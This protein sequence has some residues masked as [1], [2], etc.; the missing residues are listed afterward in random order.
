MSD[1]PSY[2]E[3]APYSIANTRIPRSRGTRTGF[4]GLARAAQLPLFA[5]TVLLSSA[6]MFLVEPMFARM[7]LPLLGGTPA[8]WNTCMVFFQICLLAGYAYA[9]VSA[10]WLNVRQQAWIQLGLLLLAILVLP[11]AV[12]RG[13]H[14]PAEGN[15]TGWL[16]ALLAV[17]VGLPFFVVSTTGP[18]IQRWM[19]CTSHR[20][21]ADPYFLYAAS[22]LGSV[23]A[24]LTYPSL[25][26]PLVRLATQSHIWTLGYGLLIV[27]T[28]LCA[29]YTPKALTTKD[30]VD[31]GAPIGMAR[32]AR[33]ILLAFVPSSLLL[34]V[35][36]FMTTDIAAV[37]LF[38]IVPLAIYLLSF[39]LVFSQRPLLPD[40]V[41]NRAL[42]IAILGVIFLMLGKVGQPIWLVLGLHLA[43]FFFTS[44][45]CHGALAKDRPSAD[46]L[47]DFYFTMSIGGVLGGLFNALLAPAIFRSAA[48]YPIM[49]VLACLILPARKSWKSDGHPKWIWMA[50]MVVATMAWSIERFLPA[51]VGVNHISIRMIW[52]GMP[53]LLS[54]ATIGHRWLFAATIAV[55]LAITGTSGLQHATLLEARRSFFGIHRV[56]L[57]ADGPFNDLYHGSTVHGRQRRGADGLPTDAETALTYYHRTGPIGQL[58]TGSGRLPS[59]P[60]IAV[61]GL[62]VGSLAAYAKEGTRLTYYEIDPT[63]RWVADESGYFTFLQAA[64]SRGADVRVVVGDARLTLQQRADHSC[65]LLVLD[66]FSG[67]AVPVHLLT[68]QA[69]QIYLSKLDS[70][71]V[72][73]IHTSN[74]YLNLLPLA[75]ALAAD[76][77]GAGIYQSDL[78][79]TP[80]DLAKGK[81]P[82]QWV[83]I[84]RS[85]A[86]LAG[87]VQDARWRPLPQPSV[88]VWTDDYSNLL[89]LFRWK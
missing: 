83:V 23:L 44:M 72:L 38:W 46:R 36:T 75:A 22:N 51:L 15:P 43:A 30:T 41:M 79:V 5:S 82:S 6:L 84:G 59:N 8:V 65:D 67:D 26:E 16:C 85:S 24:L 31:V 13:W 19:S 53:I 14:P 45:V 66:A 42:P 20:S 68:R 2:L 78:E 27:T 87:L 76:A 33:W 77:H 52:L 69:M 64:R 80:A 63:V 58:L 7:V 28:G 74:M 10:R 4:A 48:E 40:R 89:G 57:N 60:R 61:V 37:P 3:Q 55:L 47:T 21:A 1:V 25:M 32:R 73:A 17:A 62:G 71:G 39:I 11:V 56:V 34:G 49:L 86:D 35:T 88:A 50:P 9:H 81:T 12:P 18:V 70:H 29:L 54:V